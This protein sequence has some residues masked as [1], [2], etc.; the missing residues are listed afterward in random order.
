MPRHGILGLP[1]AVLA[2]ICSQ[3][4]PHCGGE[5]CLNGFELPNSFWGPDFFGSLGALALV[6]VRIGR[7]AQA[8]RFHVFCGRRDS[9]TLLARTLVEQPALAAH[10][11]VVRLGDKD[12]HG[13]WGCVVR[14]L[15]TPEAVERLKALVAPDLG[16]EFDPLRKRGEE[17]LLQ[18]FRRLL[19][20]EDS[21]FCAPSPGDVVLGVP[22][23][24]PPAW[25]PGNT[26]VAERCVANAR[27]NALILFTLAKKIKSLAI[28]SEWPLALFPEPKPCP[29][30]KVKQAIAAPDPGPLPEVEEL[31]L[32]SSNEN[33]QYRT[34]K[35]VVDIRK[36]VGLFSR[37]SNLDSLEI[38]GG[39]HTL[40]SKQLVSCQPALNNISTLNLIAT[41]TS[42]MSDI[43]QACSPNRLEYVRFTIPPNQDGILRNGNDVQGRTIANLLHEYRLSERLR[44]LYLDTSES[45]LFAANAYDVRQT[46]QT[47]PS[48]RPTFPSLRHLTISADAIYYPSQYPRV[49][50]RDPNTPGPGNGNERD[51]LVTFLP[52]TLQSLCITGV[53][54]IPTLD[55]ASLARACQQHQP[56]GGQ[57]QQ[58]Q[59]DA[60]E[61]VTLRGHRNVWTVV[62]PVAWTPYKIPE[63]SSVA[64]VCADWKEVAVYMEECGGEILDKFVRRFERVGVEFGVDMPEA[65]FDAY[66]GEWSLDLGVPSF[67]NVNS[68]LYLSVLAKIPSGDGTVGS[69]TPES[70][71]SLRTP[72]AGVIYIRVYTHFDQDE[73]DINEAG[74]YPFLGLPA[75]GVYRNFANADLLGIRIE[76]KDKLRQKWS[77]TRLFGPS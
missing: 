54:A 53:Y 17:R 61:R 14:E 1:D 73:S 39:H 33:P 43:L 28:L 36:C 57:Q 42:T 75:I 45:T 30:I 68:D 64:G 26:A 6:N 29:K 21:F 18:W 9:L 24:E 72:S 20:I 2:Q 69:N 47:I 71:A 58:Q 74:M 12:K 3:F 34:G 4:C 56:K 31:R 11:R 66:A 10:I 48:L 76:W 35:C 8:V 55:V 60:L 77:A 52:P 15:A 7:R 19:P 59:F 41:S 23:D 65:F 63:K 40:S 25:A 62:K 70:Q 46:F 44:T 22:G 32:D 50:L 37:L 38:R 67:E 51:R 16:A 27:L 5:D 13:N 49:L